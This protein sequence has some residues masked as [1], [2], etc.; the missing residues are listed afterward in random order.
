MMGMLVFIPDLGPLNFARNGVS[1]ATMGRSF[2]YQMKSGILI[3][4]LILLIAGG[5]GRPLNPSLPD[6]PAGTEWSFIAIGDSKNSELFEQHVYNI[7]Q[8]DSRPEFM[9]HLGDLVT[10]WYLDLEWKHLHSVLEPVRS[11]FHVYPVAG[12]HDVRSSEASRSIFRKEMGITGS[13]FYSFEVRGVRF[14]VLSTE[15][16]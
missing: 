9:V 13:L 1:K 12:N 2:S 11:L 5:C 15:E 10:Q 4:V 14:I 16:P 3:A 8:L 6:L 7:E